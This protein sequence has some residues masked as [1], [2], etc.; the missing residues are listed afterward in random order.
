MPS[1]SVRFTTILVLVLYGPAQVYVVRTVQ[2]RRVR[3]MLLMVA[4][5][6]MK[7]VALLSGVGDRA[8]PYRLQGL[9]GRSDHTL[10]KLGAFTMKPPCRLAATA[11]AS[12]GVLTYSRIPDVNGTRAPDVDGLRA[13]DV[14]DMRASAVV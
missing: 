2:R 4:S 11:V 7:A 3:I 12:N 8:H 6:G 9:T 14:N 5:W 10:S 13:A 1:I